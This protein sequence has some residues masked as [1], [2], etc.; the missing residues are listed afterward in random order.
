MTVQVPS[1][2][3]FYVCFFVSVCV[4]E[5]NVCVCV[6]VFEPAGHRCGHPDVFFPVPIKKPKTLLAKI[7]VRDLDQTEHFQL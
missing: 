7:N 4:C 5:F 1:G 6:C 3:C 2:L